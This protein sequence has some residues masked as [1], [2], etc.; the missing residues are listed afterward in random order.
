[1]TTHLHFSREW[2]DGYIRRIATISRPDK[3][4]MPIWM[5]VP[6]KYADWLAEHEDPLLILAL[7]ILMQQDGECRIH[8]GIDRILLENVTEYMRI[9]QLWCQGECHCPTLIPDAV[10][11]RQSTAPRAEAICAFS[12]GVDAAYALASHLAGHWGA[13]SFKVPAAV[14][15]HGAD[16]YLGQQ[17]EYDDAYVQA[18][19]ALRPLGVELIPL[20][21]NFR[22][23]AHRWIFSH[24][25]VVIAAL[26]LFGR[27]FCRAILGSDDIATKEQIIT[28][29]PYGMN[30]VTDRLLNSSVFTASPVGCDVT[31]SERCAFISA[32]PSIMEHL[33]ICWQPS[34]A[35]RNCGICEKCLRTAL[36]FMVTGCTHKPHFI[37]TPS[38]ETMQQYSIKGV[39]EYT[40]V[41]EILEYNK[42]THALPEALKNKLQ[43]ILAKAE[44]TYGRP[45][46]SNDK[47][48]SLLCLLFRAA[49]YRMSC[50]LTKGKKKQKY[51]RKLEITLGQLRHRRGDSAQ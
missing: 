30:Y 39:N 21:T 8:A 38:L 43:A 11:D 19:G 49:R 10:E 1:M 42:K 22:E 16:I 41:M 37:Q 12:G 51:E 31:R 14:L 34:S 29:I 36:N 3:E 50:A 26:A 13:L 35:G 40:A 15:I 18:E 46:A 17:S 20:R 27:R 44:A 33:R 2:H 48:P 32:F 7:N 47:A 23:Y 6:E 4:D 24:Y 45:L 25:A 9:W 5:E 28:H